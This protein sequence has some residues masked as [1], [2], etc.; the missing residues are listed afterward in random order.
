MA[1]L[2][3]P[4]I[5]HQ[6]FVKIG[7]FWI[8]RENWLKARLYLPVPG[9]KVAQWETSAAN[10]R[11][12]FVAVV[13]VCLVLYRLPYRS[14]RSV[15][16]Y[17]PP[18]RRTAQSPASH[19]NTSP[20]S[21]LAIPSHPYDC[22]IHSTRPYH[23][24]TQSWFVFYVITQNAYNYIAIHHSAL[25]NA[26]RIQLGETQNCECHISGVRARYDTC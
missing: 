21:Y 3:W 24:V 22:M 19:H 10:R 23:P 18:P 15:T 5:S 11:S 17:F 6:I 26:Q 14:P 25:L 8:V 20:P 2:F 4:V 12:V 1:L 13:K 9:Y 7:Y 16:H